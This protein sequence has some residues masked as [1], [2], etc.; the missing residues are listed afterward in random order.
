[1]VTR[2]RP[3]TFRIDQDTLRK[4]REPARQTKLSIGQVLAGLVEEGVRM[5][6]CPGIVF[7]DGPTGRRATVAGSGID[8]WEVVQVSKT[9]KDRRQLARA[10]PQLSQHQIDAAL[11]YYAHFPSEVDGRIDKN[12][13][14]LPALKI[15]P[16]FTKMVRV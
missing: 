8:V 12:E 5:R 14:C 13:I 1:M 11:T 7:T 6:K 2:N 10:L 4:V 3:V 16:P 9:C 15:R